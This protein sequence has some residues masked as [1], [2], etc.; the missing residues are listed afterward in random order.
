MEMGEN[1]RYKTDYSNLACEDLQ[2]K[3]KQ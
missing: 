3:P 1:A 2:S